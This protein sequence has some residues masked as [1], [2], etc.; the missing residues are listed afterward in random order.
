MLLTAHMHNPTPAKKFL[1]S[2]NTI[3]QNLLEGSQKCAAIRTAFLERFFA[4]MLANK[5]LALGL[6]MTTVAQP[7]A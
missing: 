2:S 4:G 7:D 5:L 1:S 6:P 3:K